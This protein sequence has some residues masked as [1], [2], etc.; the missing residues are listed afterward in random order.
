MKKNQFSVLKGRHILAQGKRRRSVALGL[1][2]NRKIVH[3]ITILNVNFLIRTKEMVF[4]I[5]QMVPFNSVR[6]EVFDLIIAFSLTVFPA[7]YITQGGVSDRSSQNCALG[8]YIQA[9]QA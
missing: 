7:F 1:K 9:L 4:F 3:A 5:R 8:Y 6:N 2:A